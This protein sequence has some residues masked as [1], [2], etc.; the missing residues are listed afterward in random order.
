MNVDAAN[1]PHFPQASSSN[2]SWPFP[3]LK[4]ETKHF[5]FPKRRARDAPSKGCLCLPE[6]HSQAQMHDTHV[7]VSSDGHTATE[8]REGGGEGGGGGGC[9]ESWDWKARVWFKDYKSISLRPSLAL[10]LTLS[11]RKCMNAIISAL[12][13]TET[14]NKQTCAS[15]STPTKDIFF[16]LRYRFA[17]LLSPC[18]MSLTLPNTTYLTSVLCICSFFLCAHLI[19]LYILDLTTRQPRATSAFPNQLI[20][21][22]WEKN[23]AFSI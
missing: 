22:N 7:H 10:S 5:C 14:D 2:E 16:T 17:I 20:T 9:G 12:F 8:R 18:R 11:I 23:N 6:A 15:L 21:N 13:K 19:F 3:N 1:S 4:P